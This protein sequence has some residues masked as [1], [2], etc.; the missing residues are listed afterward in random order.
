MPIAIEISQAVR[1]KVSR[2]RAAL[3]A[4]KFCP[5]IGAA[6]S[7]SASAKHVHVAYDRFQVDQSICIGAECGCDR[8]CVRVLGCPANQFDARMGKAFI[9]LDACVGC[10]LCADFCP[11]EAIKP[12]KIV[13]D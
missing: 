2:T 10:G 6:A 3:R 5:A 11:V 4:P 1:W 8:F 9:N 7:A 12:F 13:H